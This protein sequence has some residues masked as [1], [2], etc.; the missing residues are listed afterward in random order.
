MAGFGDL[1][2]G[3][4]ELLGRFSEVAGERTAEAAFESMSEKR[5]APGEFDASAT[6]DRYLT[7]ARRTLH[8]NDR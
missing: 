6:V 2:G 8:I 7:G 5:N 4:G 3:L 1:F